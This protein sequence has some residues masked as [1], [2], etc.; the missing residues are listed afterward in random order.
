MDGDLLFGLL[1]DCSLGWGQTSY[2][3]RYGSCLSGAEGEEKQ[4]LQRR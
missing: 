1:L 2:L 4:L 3:V